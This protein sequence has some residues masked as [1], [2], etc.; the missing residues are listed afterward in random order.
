MS[1]GRRAMAKSDE[2]EKSE[3]GSKRAKRQK[4]A[5][6]QMFSATTSLPEKPW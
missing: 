2:L 6:M 4:K 3:P 5:S 1:P